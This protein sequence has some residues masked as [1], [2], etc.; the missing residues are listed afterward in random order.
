MNIILRNFFRL[1]R[2]GVF[3]T[4]ETIEP[5]SAWKWHRLYHT[6][7]QHDVAPLL[8]DGIL[9]CRQQF[10]MQLP[11]ALEKHCLKTVSDIE[12]QNQITLDHLME[13][14]D[15]YNLQQLRPIVLKGQSIAALYP[16]PLHRPTPSVDIFLPFATQGRKA[17]Q[18]AEANATPI[19]TAHRYQ[20]AF[21]WKD[22]RVTHHH[23][24]AHLTNTLHNHALHVICDKEIR[25]NPPTRI[26]LAGKQVE[27]LSPT[28]S[29]LLLI[30][31]MTQ[32]L[33]NSGLR[34]RQLCDLGVMLR[35]TGDKTDFV[36]LQEWT[37]RLHL[38]RMAQLCGNLLE[39]LLGFTPDEIPFMR[40]ATDGR[41][42]QVVSDMELGHT[43][44]SGDWYFQQAGDI[45]VHTANSSAMLHQV[46][47]SA[48]Y[49]RYYPSE[50]I[51]NFFSSFAHSL[52]H[53][54]D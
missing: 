41:I 5:M 43:N 9:R 52:S 16:A 28:L 22:T 23:R 25:E 44:V 35:T 45:F 53:I 17:D 46:K 49:L 40:D 8:Y 3:D 42:K 26:L 2:S 27:T 34:V 31:R 54:E 32:Q 47:Q 19:A 36:K 4:E 20:Y 10:F 51:S 29:M 38:G 7:M 11:E 48:R 12:H 18:W 37:D 14:L 15:S 1:I 21:K 24:A 6:A 50:S 33:L 39:E 13:L 30:V